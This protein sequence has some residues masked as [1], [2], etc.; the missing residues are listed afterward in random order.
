MV[1]P[2]AFAVL[3]I[4]WISEL[5]LKLIASSMELDCQPFSRATSSISVK[6]SR[7]GWI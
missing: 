7:P 5:A 2:F 6:T 1:M 3:A 4:D